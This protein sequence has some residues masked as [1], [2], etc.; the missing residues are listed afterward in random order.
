MDPTGRPPDGAPERIAAPCLK[1]T[2]RVE[3]RPVV[4]RLKLEMMGQPDDV[5]CGPTCLQAVYKFHGDDIPLDQLI[6]ETAFLE[7][8][9]TLAVLLANH[10]LRRGYRATIYTY[11]VQVFDPTWFVDGAGD[12]RP[13][14]RTQAEFKTKPKL[15]Q[16]TSA[17]LEFLDLGGR[18]QMSDLTVEFLTRFLISGVP[19][20]TGL[21][22]TYL[23]RCARE[24]VE[25][26]KLSF[27][28]V[29]GVPSGHFVVLSGYDPMSR[30]VSIAD[31]HFPNPIAPTPYYQVDI[32]RLICSIMLG[33]ITYDANMLIIER[34]DERPVPAPSE[35]A[36]AKPEF[37]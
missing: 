22:S 25:G 36:P 14:L 34:G 26:H 31:P 28:D 33:I 21:S 1:R 24:V 18:L 17:Y 12:I 8:G 2:R 6:S 4:K 5:T 37:S 13:K 32:E 9:G 23:Y 3:K 30:R 15:R 7:E 16:A 11:N 10:A 29:R 35:A 20:L 19:I 27:D